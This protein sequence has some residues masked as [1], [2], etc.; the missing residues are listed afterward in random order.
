MDAAAHAIR[1]TA[2]SSKPLIIVMIDLDKFKQIN[3]EYGHGGGDK[4]LMGLGQLLLQSVRQTDFVGRYGGEEFLL[5][6]PEGEIAA[7]K[8]KIESLREAFSKVM[9]NVDGSSFHVTLS[10]GIA[11][12]ADHDGLSE[13]IAAADKALYEAKRRGKNRVEADS[14]GE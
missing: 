7:V 14:D 5:V 3:D 9:F 1:L 11:S 8:N 4:V 10:A 13:L 6:F 2:R 12:S